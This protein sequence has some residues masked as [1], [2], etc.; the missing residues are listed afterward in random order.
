[1]WAGKQAHL[2]SLH[3]WHRGQL[4]IYGTIPAGEASGPQ[5]H[6]IWALTMPTGSMSSLWFTPCFIRWRVAQIY[7]ERIRSKRQRINLDRWDFH[8]EPNQMIRRR[9]ASVA[10]SGVKHESWR[11]TIAPMKSPNPAA[12]CLPMG[13]R[14][15]YFCKGASWDFEVTVKRLGQRKKLLPEQ[16]HPDQ[17]YFNRFTPEQEI[18][19]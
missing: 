9:E 10:K 8:M 12:N 7:A 2:P 5:G 18:G 17:E 1:M 4:L 3:I 16:L 15:R 11:L 6:G 19:Q 14:S 13:S